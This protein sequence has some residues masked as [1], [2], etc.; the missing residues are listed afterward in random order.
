M[1]APRAASAWSKPLVLDKPAPSATAAERKALPKAK[2]PAKPAAPA[3]SK[4][5]V[6]LPPYR[7]APPGFSQSLQ[8]ESFVRSQFGSLFTKVRSALLLCDS[9]RWVGADFQ[10]EPLH[11]CHPIFTSTLLVKSCGRL[12]YVVRAQGRVVG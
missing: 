6:E 1:T 12:G 3:E 9:V 10:V 7:P 2:A 5:A 8:Y 4:A 11:V